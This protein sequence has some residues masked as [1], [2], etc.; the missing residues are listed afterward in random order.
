[1][2]SHLYSSLYMN[3]INPI[4]GITQCFLFYT[5]VTLHQGSVLA[6]LPLRKSNCASISCNIKFKVE[7]QYI[8]FLL[9]W[10]ARILSFEIF[11]KEI[12]FSVLFIKFYM[13]QT[14]AGGFRIYQGKKTDHDTQAGKQN[15]SLLSVS[16]SASCNCLIPIGWLNPLPTTCFWPQCLYS[17]SRRKLGLK[18]LPESRKFLE[19]RRTMEMLGTSCWKMQRTWSLMSC[20]M[21][22][23]I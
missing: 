14:C 22:W 19:H 6:L 17:K 15:S 10:A 1:M 12:F 18:L 8:P 20:C 13:R 4:T 23:K 9:P 16:V 3:S 2:S 11:S 21:E 5:L 7:C